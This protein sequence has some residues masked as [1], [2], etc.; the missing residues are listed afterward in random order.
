VEAG[1]GA[2]SDAGYSVGSAGARAVTEI[3][4]M[5]VVTVDAGG[6]SG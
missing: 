1:A 4:T 2:N 5:A 6:T 3:A